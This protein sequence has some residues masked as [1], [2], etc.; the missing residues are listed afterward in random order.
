MTQMCLLYYYSMIKLVCK[1]MMA[2]TSKYRALIDIGQAVNDHS[3]ICDTVLAA[4]ALSGCDTTA[5]INGIGKGK[6]MHALLKRVK[7]IKA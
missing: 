2:G 6:V 4:Y 1:L 5:R 7:L 3:T